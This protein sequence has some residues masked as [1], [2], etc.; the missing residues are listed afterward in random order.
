MALGRA[1]Q[2][3]FYLNLGNANSGGTHAGAVRYAGGWLTG[4]ATLN[5]NAWHFITLVDNAGTESIY[6]DGNVDAV[7][8]TMGLPLASGA[9]QIW[10]GGS[11]DGG[12]GATKMAGLIDEVYMYNRALSQAEVQALYG[13][14]YLSTNSG[15][16]LPPTSPVSVVTGARLD[17]GGVSQTVASLSGGGVV[18]NTG[19]AATLTVS[20]TTGTTTFSGNLGD[21]S[22][23][24]AL[25][26]VQSGGGTTVL[27][28]ANTYR[29]STAVK[30]GTLLVNGSIGSGAV[31]VSGG[32][33]GGS[34]NIGGAVTVQVGGTLA[35]GNNGIGA[36]TV[37]N[38]LTLAGTT[39][40]ELSKSALTNDSVVVGGTLN[41]GGTLT[42]TNLGGTLAGDDTFQLFTA[43]TNGGAF[44]AVSLPPLNFGLA[45]NTNTLTSSGVISVVATNPPAIGT[46]GLSNGV[47]GLSGT[48]SA[49]QGYTLQAATNLTPPVTWLPV[50][51]TIADTNGAFQ[52]QD[53]LTTDQ[54]LRFY[55]VSAP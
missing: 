33:L 20:N 42:V 10:I 11:P 37:N 26:L 3:T 31:T 36:L 19:A 21:V 13:K 38:S 14:N 44:T 29:S 40:M 27:T 17:L 16:V 55:R 15:N 7:T 25:S 30:G 1:R 54:P 32:T 23:G 48:G 8:S 35:P 41:Y 9:N 34:G 4:T 6:V 49:S 39:L 46:F 24:S 47:F 18:T 51:N 50:T 2:T 45:W 53:Q 43:A 52:L 22:A 12:D 5:N 28:G